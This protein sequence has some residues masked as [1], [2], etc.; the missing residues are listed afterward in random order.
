LQNRAY[1]QYGLSNGKHR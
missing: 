1:L